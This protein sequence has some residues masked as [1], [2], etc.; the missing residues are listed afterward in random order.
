MNNLPQIFLTTLNYMRIR[1]YLVSKQI[2]NGITFRGKKQELVLNLSSALYE[3]GVKN[4]KISII[5]E[6]IQVVCCR[7]GYNIFRC[8]NCSWVYN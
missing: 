2:V 7:F 5:A 8:N 6:N 1:G 3:I 4:D